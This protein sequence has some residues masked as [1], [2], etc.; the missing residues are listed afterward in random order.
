MHGLP[1]LPMTPSL[2]TGVYGPGYDPMTKFD[3]MAPIPNQ[4]IAYTQFHTT[5]FSLPS[6]MMGSDEDLSYYATN[7]PQQYPQQHLH[8]EP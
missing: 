1:N 2:N 4:S 7:L 6:S 5:P 8:L 3:F